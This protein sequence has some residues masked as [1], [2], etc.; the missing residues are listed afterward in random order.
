MFSSPVSYNPSITK[1]MGNL[2]IHLLCWYW[3]LLKVYEMSESLLSVLHPSFLQN[4]AVNSI[5]LLFEETEAERL[6]DSVVIELLSGGTKTELATNP[7]PRPPP[8]PAVP[9]LQSPV[10][11]TVCYITSTWQWDLWLILNFV[12][13]WV[14]ECW[15]GGK[16]PFMLAI[17]RN[18]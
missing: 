11:T 10:L 17:Y 15:P 6:N 13:I 5:I 8:P 2:I 9:C 3:G 16:N 12:I 14:N 18:S 4:N 1:N 7:S